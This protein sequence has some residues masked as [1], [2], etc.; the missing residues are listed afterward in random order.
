M[1]PPY[2]KLPILVPY[3]SH[4]RIPKD[5]GM[6][7]VPLPIVGG[8]IVGGSLKNSLIQCPSHMS[9]LYGGHRSS[10]KRTG[11]PFGTSVKSFTP[12]P[13]SR[14]KPTGWKGRFGKDCGE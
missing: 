8:P 14:P 4:V 13:F 3:H 6:V 2:G 1:G 5:M 12:A 7:W 11:S 10:P 9:K